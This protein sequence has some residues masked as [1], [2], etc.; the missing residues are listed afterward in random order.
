MEVVSTEFKNAIKADSRE[1]KAQVSFLS[2]TSG[3][4]FYLTTGNNGV[5]EISDALDWK[6]DGD[7][8]EPSRF[9]NKIASLETDRF[10]LD[11]SYFLPSESET[12]KYWS[13]EISDE[14]GYFSTNPYFEKDKLY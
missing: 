12:Y 3:W 14:D 8:T 11:G 13:S 9:E 5:A 2:G 4:S 1:T 6:F 10:L 7:T